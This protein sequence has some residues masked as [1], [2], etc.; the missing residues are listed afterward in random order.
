[1]GQQRGAHVSSPVSA[2][3]VG[4]S[5]STGSGRG[6]AAVRF[7]VLHINCNPSCSCTVSVCSELQADRGPASPS[8]LCGSARGA[9]PSGEGGRA[10]P[11]QTR[12]L[13]GETA[14]TRSA[15][16]LRSGPTSAGPRS[17]PIV[18]LGP[19]RLPR[20]AA[21]WAL[22][23]LVVAGPACVDLTPPAGPVDGNVPD[24]VADRPS[25][26]PDRAP[27]SGGRRPRCPRRPRP[28]RWGRCCRRRRGRGGWRRRRWPG[29]GPRLRQ[30][31]RV[32]L[33]P[34]RRQCLL[35]R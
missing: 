23:A 4:S 15:A 6:S 2:H 29:P 14:A 18:L 8:A 27:R 13:T 19:D 25:D 28:G 7:D 30:Q 10:R 16:L 35:R 1:M 26:R 12:A 22:L 3:S 21:P 5:R 32:P 34:L 31:Q 24:T 17:L 11:G 20:W 9:D 33:W